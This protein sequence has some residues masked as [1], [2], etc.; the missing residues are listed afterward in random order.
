MRKR[1]ESIGAESGKTVPLTSVLYLIPRAPKRSL[2]QLK[3]PLDIA[4]PHQHNCA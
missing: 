1:F 4:I 3:K 2:K